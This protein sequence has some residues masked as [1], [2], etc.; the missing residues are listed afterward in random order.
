MKRT[1]VFIRHAKTKPAGLFQSDF[2]R[3]L[4]ERGEQDA[5]AIGARL[6]LQGLQPDLIVSSPAK[7]AVQT[8]RKI[9]KATNFDTG[10]IN[11]EDR[12]YHAAPKVLETVISSIP[13]TVNTLFIVG[14]NPGITEFVN[15][16]S[17]LFRFD[18]MPT[19]GVIAARLEADEWTSFPLVKK[20]IFLFDYP[21]NHA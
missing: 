18:N 7:R 5:P 17:P 15:D 6:K 12:L 14:H 21:K 9:A 11:W 19:C 1:I 10:N 4:T 13:D 2:D 3:V 20:E 8:A 16:L